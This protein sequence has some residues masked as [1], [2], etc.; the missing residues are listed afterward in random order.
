MRR[1]ALPLVFALFLASMPGLAH[2][3][4]PS[5]T[6]KQKPE[7][8][9]MDYVE[10]EVGTKDGAKLNTWHFKPQTKSSH[11]VVMSHSG[12]G[13]MADYLRRVD[14]LTKLGFDVLT[15]D[16]RGYGESSE[17][18]ID[19]NMYIYPHFVTD[20]VAVLDFARD[21][22]RPTRTYLYGW[23]IGAGL[24]LGVGWHRQDIL[25]IIADT[26]FLTIEDLE[27][28]FSKWDEPM[29]VP[30][31]GYVMQQQPLNALDRAPSREI[32]VQL[33]VG[34]NDLLMKEAD[35]LKL[36][37]KQPGNFR[38]VHVVKNPDRKDNFRID[39][40][41]YMKI[42][43]DF[44]GKPVANSGNLSQV[45]ERKRPG[46][47]VDLLLMH[48]PGMVHDKW[49]VALEDLHYLMGDAPAF[50]PNK[51]TAQKAIEAYDQKDYGA[52][53]QLF[54]EVF[55][56][57]TSSPSGNDSDT[58]W[59]AL[60]FHGRNMAWIEV[61]AGCQRDGFESPPDGVEY[62]KTFRLPAMAL[63]KQGKYIQAFCLYDAGIEF[64]VLKKKVMPETFQDA[65]QRDRKIRSFLDLARSAA[66]AGGPASD[67][68]QNLG[69]V[70]NDLGSIS[71]Q[72]DVPAIRKRVGTIIDG[73][74]GKIDFAIAG[75]YARANVAWLIAQIR[76]QKGDSNGFLEARSRALDIARNGMRTESAYCELAGR[77]DRKVKRITSIHRL[78]ATLNHAQLRQLVEGVSKV[79]AGTLEDYNLRVAIS[80]VLE[81]T[82]KSLKLV[83]ETNP[84]DWP[85]RVSLA[86]LL[87]M[88]KGN[89]AGTGPVV[90]GDTGQAVSDLLTSAAKI[91]KDDPNAQYQVGRLLLRARLD[92]ARKTLKRF[93]ELAPTDPRAE[94]VK[95][96]LAGLKGGK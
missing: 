42:V 30:F 52:A 91:G 6:Y 43:F 48:G 57:I 85:S 15:F 62:D 63:E 11:L 31:A 21:T 17:F 44:L 10:A 26:P 16:Y 5:R 55:R 1:L 12:E 76:Q 14:A 72:S 49:L 36:V 87:I 50:A 7:K 38:K 45:A 27:D 75:Y 74:E 39:K 58:V 46:N 68:L 28:R 60:L 19:D 71:P 83:V 20:L 61:E 88:E 4:S 96:L 47:L 2:A 41:A 79:Q 73:L 95:S 9:G 78:S 67:V 84:N 89:Y 69:I 54:D 65:V 3:L 8:Y 90:T 82:R 70:M 40:A 22:I 53:A 92:G 77:L 66:T 86:D 33:I 24:S 37:D 18:E 34:T 13:N 35:M 93:L 56:T 59:A 23:G 25:K 81:E 80:K 94:E 64:L 29:G 51:T 32:A